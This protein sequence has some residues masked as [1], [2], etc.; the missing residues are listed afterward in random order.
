MVSSPARSA[1]ASGAPQVD[2]VEGRGVDRDLEVDVEPG[3]LE[4]D[5]DLGRLPPSSSAES[6]RLRRKSNLTT[7][8][9]RPADYARTVDVA[10]AAGGAI[11]TIKRSGSSSSGRGS[12]NPG[13][14]ALP[15][16]LRRRRRARYGAPD[17]HMIQGT[18]AFKA[19]RRASGDSPASSCPSGRC[20]GRRSSAPFERGA[21]DRRRTEREIEGRRQRAIRRW[22][23]P[24][25]NP[26]RWSTPAGPRTS[27][28]GLLRTRRR[29][30][31]ISR[32]RIGDRLANVTARSS[33]PG[34][35]C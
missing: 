24:M 35:E 2:A 8:P 20:G 25:R 19:R 10:G 17:I 33:A 1:S 12:V 28:S 27:R 22:S 14:P 5:R 3:V 30:P 29:A 32:L 4:A 31:T 6:R 18:T 23:V 15:D 13:P 21:A 16:R 34:R 9:R 26:P 7:S 11:Q